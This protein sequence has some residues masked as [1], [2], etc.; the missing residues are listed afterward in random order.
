VKT[1]KR[2]TQH[3]NPPPVVEPPVVVE[4]IVV[5]EVEE[6]EVVIE[7]KTEAPTRARRS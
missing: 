7:Q 5:E 4:E 2:D 6:K 3:I 1:H